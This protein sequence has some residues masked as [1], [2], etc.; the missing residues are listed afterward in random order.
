MM[1]S[2]SAF[3]LAVLAMFLIIDARYARADFWSDAR[4]EF[5]EWCLLFEDAPGI[6]PMPEP[7]LKSLRTCKTDGVIEDLR[8]FYEGKKPA[9]NEILIDHAKASI[10]A[11]TSECRRKLR[12]P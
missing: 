8:L 12:V 6:T 10:D 1:T 2:K 4:P 7:L 3:C 9:F 11:V 5:T